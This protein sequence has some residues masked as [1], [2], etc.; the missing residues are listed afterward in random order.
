[1]PGAF[2][3]DG[4]LGVFRPLSFVW[5]R[6]FIV[7]P[8]NARKPMDRQAIA[9]KPPLSRWPHRLAWVLACSTFLLLYVGATVTT[10]NAGMAIPDWPT[11]RGAWF[12]PPKKWLA[13]DW[14][15]FLEHGHRMLAQA[16]G[17]MTITLAVAVWRLD[18]RKWMRPLAVALLAGVVI[19]AV[20][21]GFRVLEGE[22][23]L[24]KVHGCTGPLFFGLCAA[25]VTLTSRPWLQ[26]GAPRGHPAARRVHGSA[27]AVAAA[28]YLEIVVAA[29]LRHVSPMGVPGWFAICVWAKLIVAGL[30]AAGVAW[31]LVEVLWRLPTETLIV[32]R[33]KLLAVLFLLQLILGAGTWVTN[34]GWPSWFKDY[35]WSIPYTVVAE[36]RLQVLTTTA[37]SSAGSLNLAASVSLALWS[38]RL[39][40]GA[41][42]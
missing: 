10:Y 25:L 29:Q 12:Y 19:Q 8:L 2:E 33:V 6:L 7:L 16:V 11:T 32:R 41:S 42:Q 5:T 30:I 31:L 3:H 39:L 23:L 14:D 1:M 36:G 27:L 40:R 21:G 34:Y 9:P 35:I 13:A 22:L 38:W 18:P 17:L 15:V 24:A 4:G 37:H 28:V 26:A 20:L